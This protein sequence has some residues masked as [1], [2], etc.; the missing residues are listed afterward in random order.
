MPGLSVLAVNTAIFDGHDIEIALRMIHETGFSHVEFAYNQ[1]YVG[2]LDPSLFGAENAAHLNGL[3]EKYDLDCVAL[4]CTTN[5]GSPDVIEPF[6]QRIRFASLIG[7]RFLNASVGKAEDRQQV[8][9]N[10]RLL[11]PFA[12]EHG[13]ILCLENA[14]DDNYNVF[15]TAEDGLALLKE[16][17]HPAV[18]VNIDAGN[19]VSYRQRIDPL[20]ETAALMPVCAHCHLKDVVVHPDGCLSFPALGQGGIGYAPIL[21]ELAERRIPC[22]LEIPLRMHRQA[23]KWP[24]RDAE[25]VSLDKIRTVLEQSARYVTDILG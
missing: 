17:D 12:E 5:V 23:D 8:I 22:S 19:M 20:A 10:L 14:G 4:G 9:D 11:A 3:M 7:A 2:T 18:A 25:P 6:R 16:I 15:V 21:R 1:G 24:V 13:C